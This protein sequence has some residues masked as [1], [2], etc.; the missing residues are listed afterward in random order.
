MKLFVILFILCTLCILCI[1][2]VSYKNY[3]IE[4]FRRSSGRSFKSYRSSGRSSGRSSKSYKSIKLPSKRNSVRRYVTSARYSQPKSVNTSSSKNN[5]AIRYGYTPAYAW[6]PPPPPPIT[7]PEPVGQNQLRVFSQVNFAG[8]SR[9]FS[10]GPTHEIK[11]LNNS[12]PWYKNILSF[13]LGPFTRVLFF[14]GVDWSGTKR[15][16]V[17][18][19]EYPMYVNTLDWFNYRSGSLWIGSAKPLIFAFK[20]ANFGGEKKVF[21]ETVDFVGWDWNDIIKSI[22]LGPYTVCTL[23]EHGNFGGKSVTFTNNSSE[24]RKI[25]DLNKQGFANII[26]SMKISHAKILNNIDLPGDDISGTSGISRRECMKRCKDTD[27]PRCSMTSYYPQGKS[28]WLKYLRPV[29]G[30]Y[31]FIK[32]GDGFVRVPNADLTGRDKRCYNGDYIDCYNNSKND[33]GSI[34]YIYRPSDRLCCIKQGS[35]NSQRITSFR[36]S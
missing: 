12:N 34:G 7:M 4:H 19:S 17:N 35:N 1:A 6:K 21:K 33:G 8:N 18:Y 20:Q 23:Y 22:M 25:P 13:V 10:A 24:L 15:V 32:Y 36:L 26:S 3:K 28:C 16:Y 30:I 31:T 27:N 11:N 14:D 29:G 9:V 5:W 2:V